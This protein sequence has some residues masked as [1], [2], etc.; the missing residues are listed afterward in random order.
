MLQWTRSPELSG[1]IEI[2]YGFP[3]GPIEEGMVT[4]SSV[5]SIFHSY[6]RA[7]ASSGKL[8][9]GIGIESRTLKKSYC[10]SSDE[11]S[12]RSFC[13]KIGYGE[14]ASMVIGTSTVR[15]P[16]SDRLESKSRSSREA[17]QAILVVEVR[18][19][20]CINVEISVHLGRFVYLGKICCL[21]VVGSS[22]RKFEFEFKNL[23]RRF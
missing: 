6:E 22:I 3:E 8:D 16:V 5:V 21:E 1:I 18:W 2:L 14:S 9:A 12:A 11:L 13:M 4:L 17:A 20:W 7:H 19:R 23:K 10:A 15:A